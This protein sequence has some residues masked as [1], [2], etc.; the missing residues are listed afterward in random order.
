MDFIRPI[1]PHGDL[2]PL[3]RVERLKDQQEQAEQ[4]PRKRKQRQQQPAQQPAQA[5]P[6]GPVEDD[7]GHPHIDVRV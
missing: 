6:E 7:D 1:E 2:D 3:A 5:A 4:Q